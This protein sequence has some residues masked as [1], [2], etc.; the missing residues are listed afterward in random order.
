MPKQY[1]FWNSI[2]AATSVNYA[3]MQNIA[4]SNYLSDCVARRNRA[5]EV[6]MRRPKYQ[7]LLSR[8]IM[9]NISDAI[10]AGNYEK[11]SK[12]ACIYEDNF[13][14]TLSFKSKI[15]YRQ[16]DGSISEDYI[17]ALLGWYC[18]SQA[19]IQ[20]LE[21]LVPEVTDL[22]NM[23]AGDLDGLLHFGSSNSCVNSKKINQYHML[24]F[25]SI[26]KKCEQRENFLLSPY[27]IDASKGP[28]FDFAR[29]ISIAFRTALEGKLTESLKKLIDDFTI[30]F[31][32]EG[33]QFKAE[34]IRKNQ[35]EIHDYL[36]QKL[37]S[38]I[39]MEALVFGLG[40]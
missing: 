8:N 13:R 6:S 9:L 11:F 33:P 21:F 35:R 16:I 22:T 27:T 1:Y 25:F 4:Y 30:Y 15:F 10:K 37:T 36:T 26:L 5:L 31:V 29:L 18:N 19:H 7:S 12:F 2:P 38:A 32:H 3:G 24:C 14:T 34:A 17:L 20:I 23:N 40:Y 28:K 39:R